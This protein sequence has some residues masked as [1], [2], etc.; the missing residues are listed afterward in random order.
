MG[1]DQSTE[2][3]GVGT[4]IRTSRWGPEVTGTVVDRKGA[5]LGIAWHNSFVESELQ[6]AEVEVWADAPHHLREWRGGVGVWNPAQQPGQ[7]AWA[8]EAVRGPESGL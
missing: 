8:I 6:V 3:I 2:R 7:E 5:T 4:V 1:R